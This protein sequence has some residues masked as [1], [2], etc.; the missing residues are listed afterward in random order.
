[1]IIDVSSILK[2]FGGKIDIND[3][4]VVTDDS[5]SFDGP[6]KRA[7]SITTVSRSPLRRIAAVY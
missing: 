2:E 7:V 5:F 4:L 3:E 6:V 1:M